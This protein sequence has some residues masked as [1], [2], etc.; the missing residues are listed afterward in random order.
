MNPPISNTK[1]Y[2]IKYVIPLVSSDI[3]YYGA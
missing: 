2:T 3:I 1:V